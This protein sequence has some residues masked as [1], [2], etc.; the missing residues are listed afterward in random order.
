MCICGLADSIETGFGRKRAVERNSAERQNSLCNQARR[1]VL[2]RSCRLDNGTELCGRQPFPKI[3]GVATVF[4]ALR[5]RPW[6]TL[7]KESTRTEI[8][9]VEADSR[10]EYF[11]SHALH[12]QSPPR[13]PT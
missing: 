2:W 4:L 8:L 9:G 12:S 5:W 1:R 7:V 3:L 6:R 10:S 13:T 11:R